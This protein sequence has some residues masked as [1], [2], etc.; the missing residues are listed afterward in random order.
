[1]DFEKIDEKLMGFAV[2]LLILS[3]AIFATIA[4]SLS[5]YYLVFVINKILFG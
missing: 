2:S 5:M 1:M 3:F 4:V